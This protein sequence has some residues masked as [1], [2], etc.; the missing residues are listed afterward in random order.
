M[1]ND[2]IVTKMLRNPKHSSEWINIASE[3]V[4]DYDFTEEELTPFNTDQL[5]V[6]LNSAK[7]YGAEKTRNFAKPELNSTQMQIYFA[8]YDNNL[9]DEI[10]QQFIKPEIPYNVSDYVVQAWIDGHDMRKYLDYDPEQ[11]Y[12]IFAGFVNGI[13][14]SKYDDKNINAV[15]MGLIRHALEC[16]FEVSEDDK[17]IIID[18]CKSK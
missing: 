12:E 3:I 4:A 1:K 11:I 6:I 2:A 15:I 8:G 10:L 5:K 13:D 7:K 17:S 18:I 16:G 14:V 9:D